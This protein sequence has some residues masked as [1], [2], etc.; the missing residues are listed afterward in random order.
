MHKGGWGGHLQLEG[1]GG[2]L[3]LVVVGGPQLVGGGATFSWWRGGQPQ[4][5]GGG[6]HLELVGGGG[7]NRCGARGPRGQRPTRCDL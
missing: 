7:A 2:H 5:V 6:G 1:G 3:P 4:L